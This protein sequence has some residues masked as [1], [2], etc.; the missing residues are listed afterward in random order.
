MKIEGIRSSGE[1]NL[2]IKYITY[3]TVN[4]TGRFNW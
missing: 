4:E 2:F 3:C 1:I